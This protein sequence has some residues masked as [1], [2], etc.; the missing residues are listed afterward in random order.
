VQDALEVR[1]AH[2]HVV[3][4]VEG[5]RDVVDARAARADALR[6]EP[7]ATVQ[8]ELANVGRVRRI[9]D[10]SERVHDAAARQAHRDEPRLVDAPVHLAVPKARQ[11]VARTCGVEAI[12]HAP[13]GAAAAQAHHQPGLE[14]R[15]AVAGGEDAQRAV[16]AVRPA[17]RLARVAEA[18]R[19][20]Q[21]AVAEDPEVA[22]RQPRGELGEIHFRATI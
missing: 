13:A 6:D 3:H 22:F 8:I 19:P 21:G 2:A 10:E 11:R 5:L 7:R 15:A 12:G 9:G 20:H 4:V 17:E 1:I 18:G 16:V 14:A